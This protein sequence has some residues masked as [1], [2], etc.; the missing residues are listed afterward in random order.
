MLFPRLRKLADAAAVQCPHDAEANEHRG[1]A[2]LDHQYQRLNGGL[3]FWQGGLVRRERCDIV[4]RVAKN[5]EL[6]AAG[7][8]NRLL[9]F[10]A[11][12]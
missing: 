4:V 5:D 1:A 6:S 11:P 10:P 9:E 12:A 3:L 8:R 7:Q 2:E